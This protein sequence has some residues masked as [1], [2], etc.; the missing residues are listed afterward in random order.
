MLNRMACY[1]QLLYL[2]QVPPLQFYDP[3]SGSLTGYEV[4]LVTLVAG[5]GGVACLHMHACR[6][7]V[8]SCNH[9]VSCTGRLSFV[10]YLDLFV[11]QL[12]MP[13]KLVS[14]CRST[15]LGCTCDLAPIGLARIWLLCQLESSVFASSPGFPSISVSF[16]LAQTLH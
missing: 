2:V 9:T 15:E 4:D 12:A 5:A 14:R 11:C 1:V 10:K 3:V 16:T 13:C 6:V 8:R 7:V